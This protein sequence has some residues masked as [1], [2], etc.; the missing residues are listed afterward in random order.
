ML[1]TH[2][3]VQNQHQSSSDDF[4]SMMQ[5]DMQS[6]MRSAVP[7]GLQYSRTGMVPLTEV[8]T[9]VRFASSTRFSPPRAVDVMQPGAIG[10]A[11]IHKLEQIEQ[12]RRE[13][14]RREERKE[15]TSA[16]RPL[17]SNT[18]PED[19]TAGIAL[20]IAARLPPTTRQAKAPPPPGYSG[21][22]L[23]LGQQITNTRSSRAII[24]SDQESAEGDHHRSVYR[25]DPHSGLSVVG[26][27]GAH[28]LQGQIAPSGVG[29]RRWGADPSSGEGRIQD[30]QQQLRDQQRSEMIGNWTEEVRGLSAAV[31]RIETAR[32]AVR[33]TREQAETG[34]RER[35]VIRLPTAVDLGDHSLKSHRSTACVIR[36]VLDLSYICHVM[37]D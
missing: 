34:R 16:R 10:Y 23:R 18:S 11:G 14:Q 5:A 25:R 24:D 12:L 20:R 26:G 21:A 36:K 32:E 30:D 8:Q 2:G 4:D 9:G 7:Q 31:A 17:F 19:D 37:Q 22:S 3:D 29:R 27:R 15:E 33:I 1:G 6:Q 35:Q 13:Q 28:D